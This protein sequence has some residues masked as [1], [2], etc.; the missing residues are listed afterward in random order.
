MLAISLNMLLLIYLSLTFL[1]ANC[2]VPEFCKG[3]GPALLPN[4]YLYTLKNQGFPDHPG[5]L[6]YIPSTF[7]V[8]IVP[9]NLELV[10][11]V[12]GYDNCIANIVR[13][14]EYACNCSVGGGIREAY[15]LIDQFERA[16]VDSSYTNRLFVAVEVAY[17]E[18]NDDPGRWAEPNL[19]RS[20][21]QE[22]LEVHLSSTATG[23]GAP[24]ALKDVTRVQ[25]L[26]H[27]GGY[28]TIGNI[29]AVG[30]LPDETRDLVLLDSLYADF[31]HFD[32]YVQSHL[33]VF[34][35]DKSRYRFTSVY[36]ASGGT[37][38]NNVNMEKRSENWIASNP[39]SSA[40]LL[41]DFNLESPLL[42]LDQLKEF[43]LI[44]KLSSYSHDNVARNYLYQMMMGSSTTST[45]ID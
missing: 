26:S 1:A 4:S 37:Y 21:V 30:G 32:T 23:I 17:D 35:T 16:A 24:L 14:Q 29:A 33:S 28:F 44:Y 7:E 25:I 36:T 5:A 45:M 18:A 40:T 38:N 2:S 6:V 41:D 13:K 12:H 31:E 27:S 39:N 11:W 22:L 43:S 3:Q 8:A 10:I 20:F 15:N 34:G 19:F 9:N 42:S